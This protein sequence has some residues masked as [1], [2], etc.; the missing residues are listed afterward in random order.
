MRGRDTASNMVT[1]TLSISDKAERL[2]EPRLQITP[3][4]PPTHVTDTRA[5]R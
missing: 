3:E 5:R 1:I 2:L 4:T